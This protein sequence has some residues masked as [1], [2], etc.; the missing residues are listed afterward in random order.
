[1]ANAMRFALTLVKSSGFIGLIVLLVLIT[2]CVLALCRRKRLALG[3]MLLTWQLVAINIVNLTHLGF[4]SWVDMPIQPG[5]FAEVFYWA[6]VP[7][8]FCAVPLTCV[9]LLLAIDR[10]SVRFFAD[11][12]FWIVSTLI[13]LFSV[14]L[15]QVWL[16]A[17]LFPGDFM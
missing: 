9:V 3:L 7:N 17:A 6:T 12:K 13:G 14:F 10:A 16:L 5:S 8:L 4:C 2:A 11:N 1:M 15:I